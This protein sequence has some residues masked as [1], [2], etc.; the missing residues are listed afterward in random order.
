MAIFHPS[1]MLT[2]AAPLGPMES[3]LGALAWF[4]VGFSLG[5]CGLAALLCRRL[6]RRALVP[7]SR[8]AASARGLGATDAGWS[9]DEAG[10][11]DE[12]DN[13]GRAFN[14]LLARLHIAFERQRRFN[15]DASH[16]LRTPLTVLIGQIEVAL[17]HERSGEEYRRALW[18]ALG[19]AAQL[20]QVVEALLFLSRAE[21]EAQLPQGEPLELG[22]WVADY[23]ASSTSERSRSRGR[24]P[25]DRSGRP[26]G[27]GASA[28]ARPVAR[29]LA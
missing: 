27:C 14:E 22:H 12:L 23:L 6:S 26:M 20:R 3:T 13:L 1:L 8:M 28:A 25:H 24:S 4:L 5:T 16:Q 11:G 9:L 19:R 15:G 2:V 17:R 29:E 21:E 10:T 7:L 18:S